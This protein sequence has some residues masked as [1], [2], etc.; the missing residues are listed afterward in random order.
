MMSCSEILMSKPIF[1][2]PIWRLLII[3][4]AAACILISPHRTSSAVHEQAPATAPAIHWT[5][6]GETGPAHWGALSKDF[7]ECS[8]GRKQSPINITKP[9]EEDLRNIVFNYRPA[10]VSVENTGHSI[11]V[12][13]SPGNSIEVNGSKYELVQFH[14]HAPSEHT[15]NGKHT[16]AELHLVHRNA[17]G[18]LAVVGVFI[19]TGSENRALKPVWDHLPTRAGTAKLD[20]PV[21]PES[22]LPIR[23]TTYRYEGSLT[24][25][26]CSEG[27]AWLVMTEPIQLSEKQLA[28]FDQL[29]KGNNRPVQ[30]LN[31][32]TL[33]EDM[34]R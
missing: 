14:F 22:L 3:A 11:Q 26:P 6:E 32:R 1:R 24:T 9:V 21:N 13:Y 15:L 8:V 23:R 29:F 18:Q 10:R 27:V 33:I 17:A 34:S 25:P 4:A 2:R 19:N 7:A 12:N 31:G 20:E 28:A 5:Y 30:P 16:G